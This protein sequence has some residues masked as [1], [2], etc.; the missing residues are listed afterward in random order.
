MKVAA[1][2]L[3]VVHLLIISVVVAACSG[4][5][6]GTTGGGGGNGGS[7]GSGGGGGTASGPFTI[8]GSVVGLTGTGLTLQDNGGDDLKISGTGNVNFTF[9][10]ALLAG[11]N[12]AVTIK[13]QPTNPSQACV[14]S[15]GT[16]TIVGSVSN[17][18]ISCP[19]PKFPVGGTVV[20]LVVGAG[21]TLE[22][23]DNAGDNLFVTGDVDFTFPTQFTF[24]TTYNVNLFLLPTSQG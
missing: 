21:D 2:P 8:G 24:G 4:V 17:V 22:L 6:G 11:A 13:T 19:Q 12:Y 9:A 18:Q 15:N 5:K 16:G 1:K 10:T 14:V 7:G 23:Q 3:F 20:G